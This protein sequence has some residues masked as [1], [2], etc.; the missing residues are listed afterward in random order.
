MKKI[1]AAML[2]GLMAVS[3][4]ACSNNN[5]TPN[6]TSQ[7]VSSAS[8]QESS[9]ESTLATITK[10]DST[11]DDYLTDTKLYK[12]FYE[13]V[14]GDNVHMSADG[15]M[16]MSGV[17]IS[18]SMEVQKQADVT[19]VAMNMFGINVKSITKDGYTYTLNDSE[20]KYSK[21]VAEE[22]GESTGSGGVSF[23][24]TG[25]MEDLEFIE[26]GLSSE[27]GTTD[28]EK[29]STSDS[30]MTVYFNGDE[31][32]Y[33]EIESTETSTESS[34]ETEPARI[35]VSV[36]TEI[37]ESLFEIPSDYEEVDSSE[38]YDLSSMFSTEE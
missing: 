29:Y 19:Y 11:Q 9:E 14:Q 36:S 23:N 28:Y 12:T 5:N 15:E 27:E 32:K 26:N 31:I 21:E 33:I 35:N 1:F 6:T 24:M 22:S 37:D 25:S 38:L 8:V 30:K 13:K 7:T 4:T 17:S 16:S 2:V 3:I 18:I 20:K 10:T 34:G